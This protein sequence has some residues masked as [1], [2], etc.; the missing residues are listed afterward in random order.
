MPTHATWCVCCNRATCSQSSTPFSAPL[1]RFSGLYTVICVMYFQF[2]S[3]QLNHLKISSDVLNPSSSNHL[4][5][6]ALLPKFLTWPTRFCIILP[7]ARCLTSF[8]FTFKHVNWL[9]S[10][11]LRKLRFR[12]P[13]DLCTSL[14]ISLGSFINFFTLIIPTCLLG[15]LLKVLETLPIPLIWI[16]PSILCAYITLST[17]FI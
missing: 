6:L 1:A 16:V 14:S 5:P 8:F 10:V 2:S 17:S 12:L 7:L 4:R 13:Q 9:I 3:V 15:L 11:L